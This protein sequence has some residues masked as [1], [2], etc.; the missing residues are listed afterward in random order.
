VDPSVYPDEITRAAA[1]GIAKSGFR[2]DMSVQMPAAF[3]SD[4]EF[5]DLQNFLKNPKDV[6]GAAA[7]LEADAAK[8][9]K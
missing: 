4:A 8:A 1:K 9:F 7:Q 2:F 6:N 3:G 5:S